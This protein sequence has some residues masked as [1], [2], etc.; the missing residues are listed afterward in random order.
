M[1]NSGTRSASSSSN[2][3]VKSCTGV[4]KGGVRGKVGGA[5]VK[6]N[7]SLSEANLAMTSS[8]A[9][10]FPSWT[11]LV[12]ESGIIGA[13]EGKSKGEGTVGHCCQQLEVEVECRLC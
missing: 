12:S 11:E 4:V 9:V 7:S 13:I 3:T 1:C 8:N 6:R 10:E 5:R 2:G